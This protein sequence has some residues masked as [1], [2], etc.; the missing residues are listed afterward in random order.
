MKQRSGPSCMLGSTLLWSAASDGMRAVVV[1]G[2][3]AAAAAYVAYVYYKIR[4]FS[5][6][7][8]AMSED[9]VNEAVGLESPPLR[10]L[11]LEDVEGLMKAL[12]EGELVKVDCRKWAAEQSQTI[13]PAALYDC[14][15]MCRSH[16]IERKHPFAVPLKASHDAAFGQILRDNVGKSAQRAPW[17]G[18]MGADSRFGWLGLTLLKLRSWHTMTFGNGNAM[19]K[20]ALRCRALEPVRCRI[21]IR[22][23]QH[24]PAGPHDA[25]PRQA[26]AAAARRAL[27]AHPL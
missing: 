11:P 4:K 2:A 13:N 3:A 6:E 15:I 20:G 25:R 14:Q 7:L 19:L 22:V 16:S 12:R 1:G 24:Q 17:W 5:D 10:V 23:R 21:T 8:T 9:E 18:L 27:G 26:G